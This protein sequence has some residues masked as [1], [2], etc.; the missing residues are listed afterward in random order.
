MNGRF[1]SLYKEFLK[2][3][4]VLIQ[5]LQDDNNRLKEKIPVLEKR[6]EDAESHSHLLEQY[7][8]CNNTEIAGICDSVSD[9][10]LES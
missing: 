9:E 3:K 8:R 1:D 10:D 4:D 7:G 6:V 5:R 2:L